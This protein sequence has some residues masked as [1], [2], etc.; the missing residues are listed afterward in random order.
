MSKRDINQLLARI[1][2]RGGYSRSLDGQGHWVIKNDVTG[3]SKRLPRTPSDHRGYQNG[4][5]DLRRIGYD[6]RRREPRREKKKRQ[7]DMPN[8]SEVAQ[9]TTVGGK[10]VRE[11]PDVVTD[12]RGAGR[13]LWEVIRDLAQHNNGATITHGGAAGYQWTGRLSDLMTSLWP[14]DLKPLGTKDRTYRVSRVR[15]PLTAAG[16]LVVLH[17]GNPS[18]PTTFFVRAEWSDSKPEVTPRATPPPAV[19]FTPPERA[20]E[21][22]AAPPPMPE[23]TAALLAHR[24]TPAAAE[25]GQQQAP[26]AR[27]NGAPAPARVDVDQ[28]L[29][30]LTDYDAM[31]RQRDALAELLGELS[32]VV[33]TIQA[34]LAGGDSP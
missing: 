17:P 10:S 27:V 2:K 1:D 5:R 3:A 20:N 13:F 18:T 24:S 21:P 23:R 31:I 25:Q 26:A 6:D 11:P 34:V 29:A 14:G 9:V 16:N 8:L 32:R 12:A 22:P 30:F 28:M 15:D 33:T 19:K 7:H 4:L